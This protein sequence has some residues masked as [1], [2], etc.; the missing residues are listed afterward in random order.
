[1]LGIYSAAK[2]AVKGYTDTLR[3]ELEHDGI[4]ISISLVRPASINTPFIEHARSHMDTEPEYMPSIYAPEE[5]ARAILK[6]AEH[7][8]RDVLIGAQGALIAGLAFGFPRR[9]MDGRREQ[10]GISH[11]EA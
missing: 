2:H 4:S 6:C 1:L 5:A 11:G 7:P 8:I 10:G 9:T 3:M